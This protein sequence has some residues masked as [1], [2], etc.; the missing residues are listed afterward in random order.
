MALNF[1][2]YEWPRIVKFVISDVGSEQIL[3][4]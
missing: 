4:F 1:K 3:Q 2:L